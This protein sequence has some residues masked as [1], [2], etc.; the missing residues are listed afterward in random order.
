MVKNRR[1]KE[2]VTGSDGEKAI[3]EVRELRRES[4]QSLR[5]LVDGNAIYGIKR[6]VKKP[7]NL[8]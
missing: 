4:I 2:E 6:L 3:R 8:N 7:N 1:Q 5:R